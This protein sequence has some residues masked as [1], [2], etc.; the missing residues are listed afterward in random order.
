MAIRQLVNCCG[1]SMDAASC[2]RMVSCEQKLSGETQ[3]SVS[4]SAN[5]DTKHEDPA[6]RDGFLPASNR[7]FS[8]SKLHG[9]LTAYAG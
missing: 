8:G 1:A 9:P 4:L 2:A 5:G 7:R 3:K 6:A